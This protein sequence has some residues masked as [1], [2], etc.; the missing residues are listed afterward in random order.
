[1]KTR[2]S[3]SGVFFFW[4]TFNEGAKVEQVERVGIAVQYLGQKQ[5][6]DG[7]LVDVGTFSRSRM[8]GSAVG[9]TLGASWVGKEAGLPLCCWNGVGWDGMGCLLVGDGCRFF[10]FF[11]IPCKQVS[12]RLYSGGR[13][14][15]QT[16]CVG[17][18]MCFS[19][20]AHIFS[21]RV[22]FLANESVV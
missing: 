21:I 9:R 2:Q 5:A 12:H 18:R 13:W 10:F 19:F 20:P 14:R 8:R 11:Q 4:D 15:K 22:G 16:M 3:E 6:R 7:A 17:G 1:M